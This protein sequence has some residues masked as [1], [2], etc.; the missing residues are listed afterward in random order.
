MVQ[1]RVTNCTV[2]ILSICTV[3]SPITEL[4]KSYAAITIDTSHK[5]LRTEKI[6]TGVR[7]VTVVSA[8]VVSVTVE[9]FQRALVVGT[10]ELIFLALCVAHAVFFISTNFILVIAAIVVSVTNPRFWNT[11]AFWTFKLTFSRAFFRFTHFAIFIRHVVAIRR[12]IALPVLVDALSFVFTLEHVRTAGVGAVLLVLPVGAVVVPVAHPA[13]VD[14]PAVA[15]EEGG[16][17]TDPCFNLSLAITFIRPI[18]AVIVSITDPLG[19]NAVRGFFTLN[20]I[21]MPCLGDHG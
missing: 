7:F 14:T 18:P 5:I 9:M 20:K 16:V 6:V 15:A 4:A 21:F 17:R 10:F 13:H 11:V 2:F 3:T 8:I 12:S 1:H 19:Q